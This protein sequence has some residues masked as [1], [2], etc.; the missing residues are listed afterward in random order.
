MLDALAAWD[1]CYR[2]GEDPPPGSLG[3]S[4][5]ALLDEL[6]RRIERQKRLYAVL[7]LSKTAADGA[8]GIDDVL[9]FVPGS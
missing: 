4:D 5:P 8:A 2:R 3:V 7:E 6:G 9:A 1:E